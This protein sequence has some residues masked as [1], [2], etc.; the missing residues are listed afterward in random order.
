MLRALPSAALAALLFTST[1]LPKVAK[2]P[3]PLIMALTH[4]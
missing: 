1:S 4:G 2:N 3:G